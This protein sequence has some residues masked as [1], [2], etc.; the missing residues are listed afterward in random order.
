V[1]ETAEVRIHNVE[2]HLAG[3]KIEVMLRRYLQHPEMHVR[4]LMPC[5]AGV[6]N[7]AG[8]LSLYQ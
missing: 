7:L 3:L 5:E 8:L 6:M 1:P 4:I 2:R